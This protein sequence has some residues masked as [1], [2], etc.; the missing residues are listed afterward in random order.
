[1]KRRVDQGKEEDIWMAMLI[2]LVKEEDDVSC[3]IFRVNS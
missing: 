1:M 2:G 3:S